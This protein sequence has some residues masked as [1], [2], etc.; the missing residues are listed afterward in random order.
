[1]LQ[2][3]YII[4]I[5]DDAGNFDWVVTSPQTFYPDH[6]SAEKR[7]QELIKEEEMIT[8]ANSKIQK[9]YHITN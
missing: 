7:R 6:A 5:A 2:Q 4:M 9:I 1:M 3:T 8:E